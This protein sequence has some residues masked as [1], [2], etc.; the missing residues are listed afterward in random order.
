VTAHYEILQLKTMTHAPLPLPKTDPLISVQVS[1]YALD[2]QVREAVHAYLDALDATGIDRD[3]G[4]MSTVVWGEA[5]AVWLALQSAYEA[6]AAKHSIMVNT[7]MSNAAPLP[8]RAA[9]RR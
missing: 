9:G 5:A 2:G 3:T 6:V 8:A 1:V 4:T 7:S